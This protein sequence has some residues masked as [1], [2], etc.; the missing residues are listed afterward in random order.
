[1]S[2]DIVTRLRNELNYDPPRDQVHKNLIA[3]AA[4]DIESLQ[5]K[6]N[7]QVK[8]IKEIYP[9][10]KSEILQAIKMGPPPKD[11]ACDPAC[12]DCEWYNWGL[13]FKKRIDKG[14][15]NEIID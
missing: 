9:F 12:D 2:D 5:N 7:E 8:L 13:S 11:H 15:F 6:I 4:D 1:M 3:E 14:E 10:I